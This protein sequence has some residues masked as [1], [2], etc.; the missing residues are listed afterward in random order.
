MPVTRFD[1]DYASMGRYLKTS[2]ELQAAVMAFAGDVASLARTY[3]PIGA[4]GDKHPGEFR[5]SIHAEPAV[6][7]GSIGA[8]VIA[9]S[10]DALWAEFGRGEYT[11]VG[12]NGRRYTF[13]GTKGSHALKRAGQKTNSPK[14]RA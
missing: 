2:A 12:K 13:K 8:K 9:D 10:S 7:A 3:A 14:R 5:D 4:N 1:W 11:R 6:F